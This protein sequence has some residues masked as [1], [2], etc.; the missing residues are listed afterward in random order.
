VKVTLSDCVPTL[1]AVVGVVQAKLP[2]TEAVPPVKVEEASVWP[3]VI[4]E[5]FGQAEIVGVAL[6]TVNVTLAVAVVS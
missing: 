3:Y 6:F 4:A 2:A 5:A 1:G